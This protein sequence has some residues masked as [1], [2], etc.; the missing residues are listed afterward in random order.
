MRATALVAVC[1]SVVVGC[2]PTPSA[3]SVAPR[4]EPTATSQPPARATQPSPAPS[5]TAAPT[6][7]AVRTAAPTPEAQPTPL[8]A[9][10][11]PLLDG[12]LD[13]IVPEEA[14]VGYSL[15]LED[16]ASGARTSINA[17]QSLPS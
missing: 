3:V 11:M 7:L 4:P 16:L 10:R 15:V 12:L 17:D 5:P 13:G 6:P 2:A 8:A 14:A 1:L 9:R